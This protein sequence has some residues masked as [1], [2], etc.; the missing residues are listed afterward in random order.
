[1]IGDWISEKIVSA[2]G[3]SG[4]LPTERPEEIDLALASS[5]LSCAALAL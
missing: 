3:D 4:Q 5:T 2:I 1:M